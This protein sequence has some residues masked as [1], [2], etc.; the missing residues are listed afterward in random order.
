M[1]TRS[2]ILIPITTGFLL[3]ANGSLA[4]VRLLALFPLKF[5]NCLV[6]A[7]SHRRRSPLCC[8]HLC[9]KGCQ[10]GTTAVISFVFTEKMEMG[11]RP[12]ILIP[13]T[14]SIV[15]PVKGSLSDYQHCSHSNC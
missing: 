10:Q 3:T 2:D 5:A 15:L 6:H 11:T 4:C 8:G 13:V 9:L 7:L 14:T 1:G 12:N